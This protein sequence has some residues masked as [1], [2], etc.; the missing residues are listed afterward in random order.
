MIILL[1]IILFLCTV[2]AYL[3]SPSVS[4]HFITATSAYILITLPQNRN[5]PLS[6]L[7]RYNFIWISLAALSITFYTSGY[8][9]LP[10]SRLFLPLHP[11]SQMDHPSISRPIAGSLLRFIYTLHAGLFLCQSQY[12]TPL[13]LLVLLSILPRVLSTSTTLKMFTIKHYLYFLLLIISFLPFHSIHNT[14]GQRFSSDLF[15]VRTGY[16]PPWL[17]R[18]CPLYTCTQSWR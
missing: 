13:L 1:L 7:A 18:F 2:S 14:H 8:D 6:S 10:T 12:S 9:I 16:H 15:V 17:L 3:L 4:L 5:C 11:F